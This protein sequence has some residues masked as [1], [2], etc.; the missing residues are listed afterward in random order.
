MYVVFPVSQ[1]EFL[2][3]EGER[4]KAGEHLVVKIAFSDG[5]NYDQASKINFVDVTVDRATDSVTVRAVMPNPAGMLI[6]GQ[7]VRVLV[8]GDKPDM[9]ILIPQSALVADQQGVYVFVV[10]DGKAVVRRIKPGGENGADAVVE[11]GLKPG[12]QVI[13]DGLESLRP[14]APVVAAPAARA[15]SRS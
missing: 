7:L 2:R 12:D 14:G 9:Q 13:V 4:S 6:D 11:S 10:E 5:Q 15:P 1:R 8:Q 3:L